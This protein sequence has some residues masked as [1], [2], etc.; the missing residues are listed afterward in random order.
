MKALRNYLDKIKPN[1]EEGGKFH[2][3]RSVFD[4]FE[5]FLFVPN[6][7]SKSGTH[8]HDSIDS[9]RIMSMVVIAL[10]P[11]LLFGMYNVGYQHFHATGAA[12]GF[13][14]MFIY[15]FLAVLPKIIVSY[16][17][18][19]GIEF[20]V[21]QWK[22]EEIQEGFLVSGILI[23]MI[24]PVDCPL[25]I[26]AVAT[27]FSVIFA[28]E[29]FGGTGMNVF[30]VALITRAFLFFAYPTKMSGDAVWV[31]GDSIFGLG[32]TVDGLTVATPLGAAAT[33]GAVPEFSWDM[34]T[35]LIPGSIGE[36]SVIAIALGAILLLWTGI[37][38]WKTMFSVFVGGAFMAWV[39]NAIG[40][41]TPMAQMP[42]YEHL[43]LGGFCFGAVFMATDPVTSARTETGKYIFGFLIGAMAII[44][45][46]LNPGYPEGMMLAIL[47]MNIFAP[48]IDYCAS[49]MV[50]I[51]AFLLAF[52]SS[53]LRETQNK[54]V[55]LD[56]KK[57][58]LAALNIKDVK[59]AEAEYNKYVKGDMLMNV[60]GTLTENTGAFATAY[61][62]EAKENN[63]LHVFV[64]EVDGEKK[65]VFPVY[66]AGL[67]GAIWG[68]VALNSDKDT[69][70]GVYFSHASET[71]GLGAEIASTHFQGE[72]SGKK[73]LENGEVVLGVVKNGKVEKPD[74]QVDGISGGTITSV[75]VD[76]MLKACLS[77]YKNFLTNNNEEE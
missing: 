24:V 5:T 44:I 54:N 43:V 41:D 71:P 29:V 16:V 63:R 7:T 26:L 56:T 64:A 10:V 23:P 20:V 47:L 62:K 8:I 45:R 31:S 68:Y 72:F 3:F 75:G 42:W 1:F 59:D 65:Y 22:K 51:V 76:A 36:T 50:V 74:Y 2:A 33:S 34:V 12:G 73:T 52:V 60:D 14:E 11:A 40:P 21:A 35:G 18:G 70:Y 27:A 32:Q 4:G 25:W 28:K 19:L 38:S 30:N 66:G 46:V 61:E 13:W 58:I 67:W 49:V 17:V 69:V 39:F 6:A 53:S 48:L 57:Q 9:K 55:E 77:S 37:A 15:G